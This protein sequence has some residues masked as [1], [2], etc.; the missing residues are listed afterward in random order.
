M[1]K[2]ELIKIFNSRLG[3]RDLEEALVEIDGIIQE[4]LNYWNRYNKSSGTGTTIELEVTG[5]SHTF[6]A[7]EAPDQII[8]IFDKDGEDYY[9]EYCYD[10]P[11]LSDMYPGS[12]LVKIQSAKTTLAD[13]K[14]HAD[15]PTPLSDLMFGQ[16]GQAIHN[17]LNLGQLELEISIDTESI[18]NDC[19]EKYDKA[20]EE[21]AEHTDLA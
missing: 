18:L 12:F 4:S 7:V 13:F 2:Q 15:L 14:T 1:R 21:I 20:R 3:V 16:Y 17:V 11:V 19:K 9:K 6:A 10:S 8:W 5:V